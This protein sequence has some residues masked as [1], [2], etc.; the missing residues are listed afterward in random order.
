MV[1]RHRRRQPSNRC[2]HDGKHTFRTYETAASVA[3]RLT[4]PGEAYWCPQAG[5]Y[6]IR[7]GDQADYDRRRAQGVW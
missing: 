6:H 7:R 2:S 4:E 5:G 1:T 3:A